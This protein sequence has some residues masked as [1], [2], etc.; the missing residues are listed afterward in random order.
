LPFE[1]VTAQHLVACALRIE[2]RG[3][4]EYAKRC[5][6]TASQIVLR[7][8]K[9][10]NHARIDADELP[11]L[12]RRIDAYDGSPFTRGALQLM[13]LTFVRTAELIGARW[14]EF[15]FKGKLWRIP[16]VRMKM[17]TPHIVPLSHQACEVLGELEH[18]RTSSP[19][20]FPESAITRSR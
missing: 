18:L 19:L 11:E 16:Y 12:L 10:T 20:V 4:P 14:E 15:D 13:A 6:Q 9:K 8:T 1:S 17:K 2:A 3:A 5:L 7:P